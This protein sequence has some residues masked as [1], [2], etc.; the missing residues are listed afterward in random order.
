MVFFLDQLNLVTPV[1][2][3]PDSNLNLN[4]ACAAA[5]ILCVFIPP[6]C[7]STLQPLDADGG[8]NYAIKQQMYNQFDAYADSDMDGFV[9]P[10]GRIPDSYELD[11]RLSTIKPHQA[12][13]FLNSFNAVSRNYDLIRKGWEKTGIFDVYWTAREDWIWPDCI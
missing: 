10:N 9:D 3:I 1:W 6:G 12:Q 7:T 8:V 4:E 5:N 11:L 2:S 13:W